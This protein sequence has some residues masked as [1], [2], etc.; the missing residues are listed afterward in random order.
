MAK[1]NEKNALVE[2]LEKTY[3]KVHCVT[4]DLDGQ[5]ESAYFREPNE[6]ELELA[7]THLQKGD[8]M[9]AGMVI[10]NGCWLA[11]PDSWKTN[12]KRRISAAL[13]VVEII[14]SDFPISKLGEPS[15]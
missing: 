15:A 13:C 7:F 6:Q 11:G 3:G 14:A 9:K 10:F 4:Q 2:E 5:I 8:K 1:K 12:A